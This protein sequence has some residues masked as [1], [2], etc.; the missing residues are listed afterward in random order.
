M[1]TPWI[2]PSFVVAT[3]WQFMWQRDVGIV[4]K[5]LVDTSESS[6]SARLAV[7]RQLAVGDHHPEHLARPAAGHAAS[8]SPALPAIPRELHEAAAIDGAGAVAPLPPHHAAAAA[9]AHRRPAAVRRHLRVYQFSIPYVMFGTNPGPDADLMMT[10]IVRQSF[11]NS[12]FGFGAAASTLL[13]VRDAG[14]GAD[15]V[16]RLPARPGGAA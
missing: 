9:A 11:S 4:N 3:L 15:L 10:L 7:R 5:I 14:L 16:P 1:L 12:L 13:M 8:S 6:A 2:V